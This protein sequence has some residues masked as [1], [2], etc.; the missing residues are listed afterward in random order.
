MATRQWRRSN[1]GEALSLPST[2]PDFR[3]QADAASSAVL[4]SL[5]ISIDSQELTS[6]GVSLCV[7]AARDTEQNRKRL[8]RSIIVQ[9]TLT[10][11]AV[12]VGG[13]LIVASLRSVAGIPDQT[14]DLIRG[15]GIALFAVGW[16]AVCGAVDIQNMLVRR[17]LRRLG[18]AVL[19][20]RPSEP[21]VNVNIEDPQ[22]GHKTKLVV[23][24][25]GRLYCDAARDLIVIEG[26]LYRYLIWG[27]D[28]I[29][30]E[31]YQPKSTRHHILSYRVAGTDTLLSIAMSHNTVFLEL[32][33]QLTANRAAPPLAGMLERSLKI[34]VLRH[35]SGF[36]VL[37][38]LQ[39]QALTHPTELNAPTAFQPQSPAIPLPPLPQRRDDRNL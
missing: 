20:F 34:Q 17:L 36:P 16:L 24:D 37:L 29:H 25:M 13:A 15:L 18:A 1:G 21:P 2:N 33:R 10:F 5:R 30:C 19:A 31:I 23:E 14:R 35:G 27:C 22:T 39:Q 8:V 11:G 9:L 6:A 12:L 7:R 32:Q 38:P 4:K 28:V 26:V 3:D